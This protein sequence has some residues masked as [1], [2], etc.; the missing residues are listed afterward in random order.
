MA[1]LMVLLMALLMVCPQAM[2]VPLHPPPVK[3]WML[4]P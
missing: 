1:L 3:D 2:G 4:N